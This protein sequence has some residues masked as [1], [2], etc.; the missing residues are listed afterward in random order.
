MFNELNNIDEE[1]LCALENV[2]QQ[3][4]RVSRFYNKRLKLKHLV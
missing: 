2:I 3:I 1:R 4:E